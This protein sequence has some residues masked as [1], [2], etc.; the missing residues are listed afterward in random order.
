MNLRI[1]SSLLGLPNPCVDCPWKT[2]TTGTRVP[3]L[4]WRLHFKCTICWPSYIQYVWPQINHSVWRFFFFFQQASFFLLN[5]QISWWQQHWFWRLNPLNPLNPQCEIPKTSATFVTPLEKGPHSQY[6]IYHIQYPFYKYITHIPLHHHSGTIYCFML[7]ILHTHDLH[8]HVL[9]VH[10]LSSLSKRA[11]HWRR[12]PKR[13]EDWGPA[14]ATSRAGGNQ[15]GRW[16]ADMVEDNPRECNW[17][18]VVRKPDVMKY[19]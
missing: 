10:L 4:L 12:C 9:W 16:G 15:R 1:G 5:P 7:S 11:W 19:I 3:C 14:A 6:Q 8:R 17:V 18:V 13:V 2:V